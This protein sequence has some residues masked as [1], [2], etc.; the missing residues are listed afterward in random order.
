M[1]VLKK[2]KKASPKTKVIMLSAQDSLHIAIDCLENGAY[3]YISKTDT[4]YVRINNLIT[5]IIGNIE[6]NSPLS[7]IFQYVFWIFI[8]AIIVLVILNHS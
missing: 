1:A 8:L 3:D 6:V 7:K 4:A 2:I 5:N